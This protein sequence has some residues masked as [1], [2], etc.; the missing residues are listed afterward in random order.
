MKQKQPKQ[1]PAATMFDYEDL[2]LWSGT[3]QQAN[4]SPF[5]QPPAPPAPPAEQLS[6][7]PD[8]PAQKPA[9]IH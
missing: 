8:E 6:L 3:P 5:E 4:D 2:P 9:Q 1:T 7:F